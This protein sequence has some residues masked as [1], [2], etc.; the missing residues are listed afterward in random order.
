[1]IEP[2]MLAK[3]MCF[4]PN[5]WNFRAVAGGLIEA[6]GAD[7]VTGEPEIISTIS[8]WLEHPQI[9]RRL[10]ENARAYIQTQSGA[11]DRTV[12]RIVE[13]L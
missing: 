13:L 5:Y 7:L 10:G 1:M 8:N 2:A 12:S 3:P 9:A 11:T 4:G 6:G